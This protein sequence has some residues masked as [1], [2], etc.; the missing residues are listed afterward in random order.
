M[1]IFDIKIKKFLKSGKFIFISILV[2]GFFLR[3]YKLE[4]LFLY[5][6]D[7]DLASWFVKDVVINKHL[8]LIGQETSTQ[9]IF[10]GPIYYYFLIPFYLVF[11]MDPIAGTVAIT[12]LGLFS[13]FSFYY[14][15]KKIFGEREG[16]IASFLFATSF[17]T[18]FNDREVVPTMPVIVW[19][20]WY[21]YG[22]NQL[23]KNRQKEGFIILGVL[24]GLIW[25]INMAL[26]L[27]V[28]LIP[29]VSYLSGKRVSLKE[30]SKGLLFI[31]IFSLPLIVFESRHN[32]V[33]TK[34]LFL[35]LTTDQ[36]DI[37]SGYEKFR[38]VIHLLSKDASGFIWG[39][40]EI[41]SYETTFYL[42]ILLFVILFVKGLIA[43]RHA[44]LL[45]LW[46]IFYIGFFSLYS[47]ILS[48]YYLNGTIFI[49]ILLLTIGLS[50][51][52]TKKKYKS[53]TIASLVFFGF[54][55]FNK[56]FSLNINKS[57]YLYRKAVVTE[58]KRDFQTR[59]FPCVAVS[60]ITNPGYDLG[61]RYLFFLQ[62]MHVNRPES[63]SP[64][65]TIVFP[66]KEIF[67]VDKTFGAIGL[68][69]PDYTRYTKE[70]VEYSCSG[71]N[72]NLTDPMFGF[73]N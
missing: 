44:T 52:F 3:I 4:E 68:I 27:L 9:G 33:Q 6:H 2:L 10:I 42:L 43:I 65:Y 54:F 5:G 53:L 28:P 48:E 41:V 35:S 49:W 63:G 11:D 50:Y 67:P 73:T 30:L 19:T 36:Y 22:L 15:F 16:L 51:F 14:V 37:I 21:F 70:N 40:F 12:T 66:L 45:S 72:S 17:Y 8:R 46:L 34:S 55:N 57:G 23:L 38:Q 59:S 20:C 69:Y 13:I 64:V 60:Y 56:F 71:E 7:Q 58:I 25:H 32:F 29:I 31:F 1:R 47:K 39:S 61:Y 18:V 62:E 26:I 24:L